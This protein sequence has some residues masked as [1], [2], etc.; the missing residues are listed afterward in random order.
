M[1]LDQ[2]IDAVALE[3]VAIDNVVLDAVAVVYHK[4]EVDHHSGEVPV[5]V[6]TIRIVWGEPVVCPELLLRKTVHDE[7]SA[8][9]HRVGGQIG[10]SA[11][12]PQVVVVDLVEVDGDVDDGVGVVGVLVDVPATLQQGGG[13]QKKRGDEDVFHTAKIVC[14]C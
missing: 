10:I 3:E 1:V 11:H 5:F 12:H 7:S 2:W 6:T 8:G 9:A 14:F 4:G 13:N